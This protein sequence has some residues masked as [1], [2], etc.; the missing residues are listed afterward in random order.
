MTPCGRRT[1]R[2]SRNNFL[3]PTMK[4]IASRSFKVL[5]HSSLPPRSHEVAPDCDLIRPQHED[6]KSG[7]HRSFPKPE[8]QTAGVQRTQNHPGGHS[9]S[10]KGSYAPAAQGTY[11]QT[12]QEQNLDLRHPAGQPT[13]PGRRAASPPEWREPY[14]LELYGGDRRRCDG[15]GGGGGLPLQGPVCKI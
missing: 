11:S 3:Y 10:S 4:K 5:P 14:T 1:T 15:W 2:A 12:Y 8:C 13:T 7:H 9:Q 6:S